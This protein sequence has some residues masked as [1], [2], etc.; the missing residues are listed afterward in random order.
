MCLKKI[1]LLDMNKEQLEK[2]LCQLGEKSFRV[3]QLMRWIYRDYC[4][5]FNYMTDLS[6]SLRMKLNRIAEIRAPIIKKER[7]SLDGTIKWS[8]QVVDNQEIETVYI[9]ER[10]RSTLCVSSQIGCAMGCNFCGTAQQGFSRNLRVSEIVGQIWK[11]SR[12]IA[13]G[14]NINMKNSLPIT[15][16]VFMGMGE[17]LLNLI[18]VISSIKIILDKFGF[19]VSKKHVVIS[20]V[21][22][23]P[24]ID[25]LKKMFFDISLAISLHAP[26]DVI[27]NKIMPINKKYNIGNLLGA[28]RRYL[29]GSKANYGQV[30]IEYV[31]LKYVNDDVSHAHQLA[32]QLKNIPCKIN[33][34]PW[35][36]IPNVNYMCSSDIRVNAF[37]QVLLKYGIFTIVRKTRGADIE[38][39][40]GQLTGIVNNRMKKYCN[41]IDHVHSNIVDIF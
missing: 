33:L 14:E 39:A 6:K 41:M 37:L 28:V 1:N 20:T 24:A 30:T 19:G 38:A 25:K 31:L 4:N 34:I 16:V 3:H 12:F 36:F 22:I 10:T 32:Q 35:N 2:F 5:N 21:G 17:P 23:V 29:I 40:C 9:P 27:R 7:L 11:I 26:N 13:L 15:H 18:N 8:M